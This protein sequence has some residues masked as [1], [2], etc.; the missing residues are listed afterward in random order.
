MSSSALALAG[1][2][3]VESAVILSRLA[4]TAVSIPIDDVV[5]EQDGHVFSDH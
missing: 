2:R 3:V 4:K 5:R 1:F